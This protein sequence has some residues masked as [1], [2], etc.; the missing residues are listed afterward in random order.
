MYR[1][2]L[3]VS[4]AH[5]AIVS[6]ASPLAIYYVYS[7]YRYLRSRPNHLYDRL[8]SKAIESSAA[9]SLSS[10]SY[11]GSRLTAS[12]TSAISFKHEQC[13]VTIK[14]WLGDI[15]GEYRRHM[16]K[17]TP[18]RHFRW[19]Q[20]IGL[21]IKSFMVAQWD[22]IAKSHRWLFGLMIFIAYL[23]WAGSLA[24]WE[25]DI[26]KYYHDMVLNPTWTYE[27]PEKF[28]LLAYSQSLF[29]PLQSYLSKAGAQFYLGSKTVPGR[30]GEALYSS[31]RGGTTPG[32]RSWK[33]NVPPAPNQFKQL[34]LPE[35]LKSPGGPNSKDIDI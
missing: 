19:I 5:F 18:W 34:I 33:D 28:N 9:S 6:T 25:I 14:S 1:H 23:S 24:V 30:Y 32:E 8:N 10:S 3:S 35:T 31:S 17:A 22:V 16:Q 21:A 15:R 2:D 11:G 20:T 7:T 29:G 4:D 12:S 13:K 26:G 27:H